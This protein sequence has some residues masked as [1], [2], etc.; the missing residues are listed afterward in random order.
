MKYASSTLRGNIQLWFAD[1]VLKSVKPAEQDKKP[2][3]PKDDFPEAHKEVNY[4]FSGADSYGSKRKKHTT[5]EV[6]AVG[7]TIPKYLKWSEVLVTFNRSDY[8]D[9]IMKL[10]QYPLIVNPVIKD[11]K[12][13]RV[14]IDGGSSLNIMLLKTFNQ[15][16][17]PRSMLWSSR[18][19]FHG[20]VPGVAVTSNSQITLP[21]TFGTQGNF[22][23]KYMQ[24]DVAD[25][26]TT[27]NAF[28]ERSVLSKFMAIAHYAYLVLKMVDPNG[29]IDIKGDVKW[30]YDCDRES[31]E[32]INA[33]LASVELQDLK[34][35]LTKSPAPNPIM[36]EFKTSKLS[37]QL[38]DKLSKAI[39]LSLSDPSKVAHVGNNLYPK[40]ELTIIKFFEEGS[41]IFAWKPI[42]MSGV[43]RELIEHKLHINPNFKPVKQHL[44]YFSQD[45]KDVIKRETARLIDA[46]FIKEVYHPD[47][48]GNP[49]LV[50]KKNK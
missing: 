5:Q 26:E 9:F 8:L 1:E 4:I 13:N 44:R 31:Y 29:V 35:A 41:D 45:K 23:T 30:A 25:F 27:Y 37:M 19:P 32:M 47:W 50:S 43:P 10:G 42:D 17:L 11:V 49:V 48:L 6:M 20:I 12:L 39:P 15:M 28:L 2:E 14:L 22:C 36:P 21:I 34:K 40:Y 16:G 7:P 46:G 18:A 38:E 24:F 3:E 33:L